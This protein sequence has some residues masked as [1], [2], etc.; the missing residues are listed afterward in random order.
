MGNGE[1]YPVT[2]TPIDPDSLAGVVQAYLEPLALLGADGVR[3]HLLVKLAAELDAAPPA[4]ALPR[5]ASQIR[6]LLGEIGDATRKGN[7][8]VDV[9]AL[10][11]A[12]S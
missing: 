4:H 3:A 9:K 7:G 8:K 11:E 6:S 2:S 12:V 5:Y 10:L 1:P